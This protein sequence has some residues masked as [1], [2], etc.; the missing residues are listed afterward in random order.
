[1][2]RETVCKTSASLRTIQKPW[3]DQPNEKEE[4]EEQD[5]E[6]PEDEE[7]EGGDTSDGN[8]DQVMVD[9]DA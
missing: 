3:Y 9:R 1:V 7:E 8:E 4:G 5:D 6:I 2:V